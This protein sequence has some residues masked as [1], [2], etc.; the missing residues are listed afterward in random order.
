M[1][2]QLPESSVREILQARILEWI[3]LPFSRG[4]S[5][6][7]DQSQVSHTAGKFFTVWATK[8]AHRTTISSSNSTY[9]YLFN[10]N[11]NTN[12]KRYIDLHIYSSIIYNNQDIKT[13][14]WQINR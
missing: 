2:C 8:E 9:V 14:S 1:D 4:S 7:R 11:V 10:E 13:T 5:Q 12:S 6:S 3:A